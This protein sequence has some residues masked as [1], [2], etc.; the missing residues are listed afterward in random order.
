MAVTETGVR[1]SST[2]RPGP[3]LTCS[4]RETPQRL[5]HAFPMLQLFPNLSID[6]PYVNACWEAPDR[7]ARGRRH[8]DLSGSETS[9]GHERSATVVLLS[10][11]CRGT[12][13]TLRTGGQLAF[14]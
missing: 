4:W 8:T 3:R 1:V 2:H 6:V 10:P 11:R 12:Q 14:A 13:T 7:A 5:R 9:Q